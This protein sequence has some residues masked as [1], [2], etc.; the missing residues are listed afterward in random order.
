MIDYKK[1][2]KEL[3]DFIDWSK[4]QRCDFANYLYNKGKYEIVTHDLHKPNVF[5][6]VLNDIY[7]DILYYKSK[8]KR[9]KMMLDLLFSLGTNEEITRT[10]YKWTEENGI[11]E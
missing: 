6:S 3:E 11:T 9:K 1:S 2:A 5:I 10:E 7:D 4:D 8:K